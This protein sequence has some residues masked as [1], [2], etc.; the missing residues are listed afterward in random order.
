MEKFKLR[1]IISADI[2][3][4][5]QQIGF[6]EGYRVAASCKY[7]YKNLKIYDLTPAQANIVKQ[8]AIACGADCATHRDVITGKVEHSDVILGGSESELKKIAEKLKQQP[9]K[10]DELGNTIVESLNIKKRTTMLVGILNITPDSF[11]DGGLYFNPSDSQKHLMQMIE[12]GADMIDIGAESTRPF[13]E[14]VVSEEQ[15]KRLKPIL[16]FIQKEN[17]NVPISV[18]TRNSVVADF[19]LS[20]G[21]NIINDVSGFDFD[22]NMVNIVAKHEAGVIIQHSKGTPET[23]Q[24]APQYTNLM[25]EIYRALQEKAEYAKSLG[26]K[27]IIIDPGIGFGKTNDDNFEIIDRCE[28][29]FSMGYPVMIGI[30]RKSLLQ[31]TEANNELKDTLSVALSYPLARIGVDYLRV[32]NIKLHKKMLNLIKSYPTV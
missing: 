1:Q 29:F 31:I 20:S 22:K 4:E 30:S 11:S 25:E 17:I 14:E 19:A 6:D 2:E 3:K 16:E 23:M 24:V 9:F 13:S 27:E 28:E 26:I 5:L 8:T 7:K 18:D 10:L 21:A 32:H 12:D 15:V